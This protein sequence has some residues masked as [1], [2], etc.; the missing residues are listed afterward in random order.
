[1]VPCSAGYWCQPQPDHKSQCTLLVLIEF[2]FKLC[3][4]PMESHWMWKASFGLFSLDHIG[5]RCLMIFLLDHLLYL[6]LSSLNTLMSIRS[7]A[8]HN[9]VNDDSTK[10]LIFSILLASKTVIFDDPHMICE[11]LDAYK[12]NWYDCRC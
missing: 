7:T 8:S 5:C 12:I 11:Y 4:W 6:I 3:D 10:Q 1:M 2:T 9:H